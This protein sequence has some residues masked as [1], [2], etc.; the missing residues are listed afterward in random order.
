MHLQVQVRQGGREH[1]QGV[2]QKLCAFVA[3]ARRPSP[4]TCR[5]KRPQRNVLGH[6]CDESKP[7]RYSQLCIA[8]T[9]ALLR[10]AW[11]LHAQQCPSLCNLAHAEHTW[12][13]PMRYK[14]SRYCHQH[15]PCSTQSLHGSWLSASPCVYGQASPRV[16]VPCMAARQAMSA[17]TGLPSC[18]A[19]HLSPYAQRPMR[20]C[21]QAHQ[22]MVQGGA[23]CVM[24][25]H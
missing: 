8:S 21:L 7:G 13:Q 6:C 1:A 18:E 12:V 3:C 10:Y 15:S 25:L 23:S 22:Q 19:L 24:R 2:G 17:V 14:I 20:K 11:Q 9:P 4:T 5:C 16:H